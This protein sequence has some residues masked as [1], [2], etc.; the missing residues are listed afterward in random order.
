MPSVGRAV[1]E[2]M[3]ET[4]GE[5]LAERPNLFVAT[6]RLPAPEAD[7]LRQKLHAS[8]ARLVM[9]KRRLGRRTVE[10]LNVSGLTDLLEGSVGFVF[11]GGDTL[12]L[13]KLL[14]EFQKTHEERLVIRGAVIDGQLLDQRRVEH[15]AA[16]PP[17]PQLL[18]QVVLTVESPIVDVIFTVERLIGDLIWNID[19]VAAKS[20]PATETPAQQPKSE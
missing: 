15:L 18:A 1:K 19:Q 8:Q 16:L 13:A 2:S 7:S 14:V 12:P 17:K 9:I 11:A 20:S 5:H 6:L 10:R 3:I 4:L